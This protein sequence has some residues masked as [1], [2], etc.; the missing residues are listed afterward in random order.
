MNRKFETQGVFFTSI[1]EFVKEEEKVEPHSDS[2]DELSDTDDELVVTQA[3]KELHEFQVWHGSTEKEAKNEIDHLHMRS[4][5]SVESFYNHF[6]R[7]HQNSKVAS[8]LK[9]PRFK[10]RRAK[11][12]ILRR[13]EENMKKYMVSKLST[14]NLKLHIS[15]QK[16]NLLK[17]F[18]DFIYQQFLTQKVS[19]VLF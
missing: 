11:S 13:Q 5:S 16:R 19:R 4:S 7:D 3:N 12:Q 9:M 14:L 2:E 8:P 10:L 17:A 1:D 15:D 18:D 6:H